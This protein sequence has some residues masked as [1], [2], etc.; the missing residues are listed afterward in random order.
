ML[1][2]IFVAILVIVVMASL[3]VIFGMI[4]AMWH[5]SGQGEYDTFD[6]FGVM[7]AWPKFLWCKIIDIRWE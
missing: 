7:I 5:V 1:T 3:Y 6:F 4:T 2:T